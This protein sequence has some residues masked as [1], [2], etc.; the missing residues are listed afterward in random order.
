MSLESSCIS[1]SGSNIENNSDGCSGIPSS[2]AKY[3]SFISLFS[4]IAY[5][6]CKIIT[7]KSRQIFVVFYIICEHEGY[8]RSKMKTI[9]AIDT[10][11]KEGS[12][13]L[14]RNEILLSQ[15]ILE[16]RNQTKEIT[17]IIKKI[18]SD[19]SLTL[20]DLNGI[21]VCIGPGFYTGTRIGV[22]NAKTLSFSLDL[23][24]YPFT[25]FEIFKE[26]YP[27]AMLDAKCGRT[28]LYKKGEISIVKNNTL[29]IS[30][31]TYYINEN[32]L[33]HKEGLLVKTNKDILNISSSALR[34]SPVQYNDLKILYP[35]SI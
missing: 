26:S 28:Y 25:S 1:S 20:S 35:N 3:N 29:E 33:S 19:N 7:R 18:L 8:T 4:K 5:I 15:I 14:I 30:E 23:P 21:A 16:E 17:P 34:K 31:K 6:L 13:S 9:L 2:Q 11:T 22:M 27:S 10:A 12:I 24:L 32:H